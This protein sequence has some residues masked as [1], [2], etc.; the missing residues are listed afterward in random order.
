MDFSLK[1]IDIV[2]RTSRPV[3]CD[4]PICFFC[5]FVFENYI[6]AICHEIYYDVHGKPW[7]AKHEII[8]YTRNTYNHSTPVYFMARMQ[9]GR[10]GIGWVVVV[11]VG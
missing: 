10:I 8:L 6:Y 5:V 3:T 2:V 9:F 11:C 4:T 1:S 7:P